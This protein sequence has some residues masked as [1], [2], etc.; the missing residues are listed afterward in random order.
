M[1]SRFFFVES[2]LFIFKRCNTLI[3]Q[4]RS[5]TSMFGLFS[6]SEVIFQLLDIFLDLSGDSASRVAARRMEFS[7]ATTSTFEQNFLGLGKNFMSANVADTLLNLPSIVAVQPSG[8]IGDCPKLHRGTRAG[9]CYNVTPSYTG[10]YFLRYVE[11]QTNYSST[12]FNNFMWYHWGKYLILLS[13]RLPFF[14][15]HL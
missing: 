8:G 2:D 7:H 1:R 15:R 4:K 3:L 9:K 12:F 11:I 14:S 6:H 5:S 13:Q 10:R